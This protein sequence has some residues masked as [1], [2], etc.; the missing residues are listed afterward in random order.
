M[1]TGN[2]HPGS[3]SRTNA[4]CFRQHP[5]LALLAP[6]SLCISPSKSQMPT[7]GSPNPQRASLEVCC[8]AF[9][10]WCI[11]LLGL[12][13]WKYHRLRGLQHKFVFSQFWRLEVQ[14]QWAGGSGFSW[15]HSPLL[16]MATTDLTCSFLYV[17]MSLV[18]LPLLVGTP[19]M[20]GRASLSRVH[21]S[22]L[23]SLKA[24]SSMQSHWA[25]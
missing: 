2:T 25:G 21:W 8:E 19:V 13:S 10:T 20:L 18:S 12:P 7:P 17:L 4:F 1:T 9:L 16:E 24:L 23:A 15:R 5:T 3:I 6:T 22:L 14:D 11:G